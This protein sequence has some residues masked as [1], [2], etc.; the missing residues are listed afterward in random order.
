MS[1]H[2]PQMNE[3]GM[4][5]VEPGDAVWQED[6]GWLTVLDTNLPATKKGSEVVERSAVVQTEKAKLAL[7]LVGRYNCEA[8]VVAL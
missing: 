5:K 2:Y 1:K 8:T 4:E 6:Y 7:L 3:E